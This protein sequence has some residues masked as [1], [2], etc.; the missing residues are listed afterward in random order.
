MN[1]DDRARIMAHAIKRMRDANIALADARD[2]LASL[3]DVGF[4]T[5]ELRDA[6]A[7]TQVTITHLSRQI[8]R[9]AASD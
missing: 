6:K 7:Q 8:R 4:V 3:D 5:G 9:E 1:R 2:D